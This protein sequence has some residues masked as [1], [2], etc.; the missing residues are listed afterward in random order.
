[1]LLFLTLIVAS[2]AADDNA[3]EKQ[4]L[5][6]KALADYVRTHQN[7][8]Q[9]EE[10]EKNDQRMKYLMPASFM[11]TPSDVDR[12]KVEAEDEEPPERFDAR[13]AWPYCK[14]I[15]GKI[16][17]QSHCGS[18]W[19]VSAAETMSDRLC[20][21]SKGKFKLHLS[22]TDILACCGE[23]CGAGCEGGWPIKAWQF[24]VRYGV[25]T[26]GKYGAKGVCKPYSFHPCGNHKN[27]MYYGECPN[28]SWPTPKCK[29]F[30]QRGYTK[31]YNKD[32]FYA[33][34]AYQLPRDEKKIRLEIMKNGPVQAGYFVYEDFRLYKG[35]IYKHKTGR[36]TGGH[37]V[38]I[39]GWGKENVNGTD[40]SYWLIANSWNIDWGEKGFFR[41]VRGENDCNIEEMIYA[42]MMS[43]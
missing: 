6:G 16:R 9:V 29:K 17:D 10:S 23:S 38:K 5:T 7:L 4:Q 24:I 22:D 28:S 27:Q 41:M 35:G 34:N 39:I 8:F 12:I 43:V 25:C 13:E 1:M 3:I 15:I 18:C 2:F 14:D 33:K 21:Q 30:C 19:A 42:G 32:K 20:V 26:G 31:T 11:T 36:Q 37:A 40:V